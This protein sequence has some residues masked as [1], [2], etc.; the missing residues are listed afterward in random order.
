[1]KVLRLYR[2]KHV[3]FLHCI[4]AVIYVPKSSVTMHLFSS[5]SPVC[6]ICLVKQLS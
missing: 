2:I 5:L 1:M 3:D 4:F 6:F